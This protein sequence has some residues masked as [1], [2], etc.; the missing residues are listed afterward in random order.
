MAFQQYQE[1]TPISQNFVFLILF[2]FEWQNGSIFNNSC[3]VALQNHLG[4]PLFNKGFAIVPRAW[5]EVGRSWHDE[6]N[7]KK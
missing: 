2:N 3:F 1:C 5:W 4:A 7:K 6:H